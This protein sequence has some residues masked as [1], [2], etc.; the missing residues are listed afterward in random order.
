MLVD[1]IGHADTQ[2]DQN[3]FCSDNILVICGALD[4]HKNQI[5]YHIQFY[6][7]QELIKYVQSQPDCL[8]LH[9]MICHPLQHECM[10]DGASL[11]SRVSGQGLSR[12]GAGIVVTCSAPA[13]SESCTCHRSVGARAHTRTYVEMH[14]KLANSLGN[15]IGHHEVLGCC[16]QAV[17]RVL[18]TL[19]INLTNILENQEKV[20]NVLKP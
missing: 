8:W 19:T 15:S 1:V 16:A 9:W 17:H 14:D 7:W 6:G 11:T 2:I 12:Y 4:P 5:N 18:S 20:G 13:L 10:H 3:S